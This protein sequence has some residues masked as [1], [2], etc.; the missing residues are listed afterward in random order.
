MSR[1]PTRAKKPKNRKGGGKARKRA[2]RT[3]P[4]REEDMVLEEE[5]YSYE[6]S[7]R[8]DRDDA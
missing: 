2:R 7:F 1:A 3:K 5:K 8:P 6:G 4:K